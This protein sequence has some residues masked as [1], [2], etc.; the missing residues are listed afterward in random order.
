MKKF[1]VP[2]KYHFRGNSKCLQRSNEMSLALLKVDLGPF[3]RRKKDMMTSHP[4]KHF[5]LNSPK[6]GIKT[7]LLKCIPLE[8][9]KKKNGKL[10]QRFR[11]LACVAIG[12]GDGSIAIGEKLEFLE[13]WRNTKP[14][15]K[16]REMSISLGSV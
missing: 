8:Y 2:M 16:H 4:S 9:M 13:F 12:D 6:P 5:R 10:Q 7:G 1:P 11:Y 3:G 15:R 14:K